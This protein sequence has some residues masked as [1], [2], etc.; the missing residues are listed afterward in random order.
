MSLTEKAGRIVARSEAIAKAPILQQ[1]GLIKNLLPDVGDYM[2]QSAD[3]IER[4]A[5][6]IE[7]LRFELKDL[8]N[9]LGGVIGYGA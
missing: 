9:K 5:K 6:E 4:Q 8:K 2:Q 3:I 1:I 7:N